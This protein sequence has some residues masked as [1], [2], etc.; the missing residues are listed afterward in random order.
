MQKK[1]ISTLIVIIVLTVA[2]GFLAQKKAVPLPGKFSIATSFYVLG[3]FVENIA[4][5]TVS[6]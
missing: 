6:V 3:N 5:D 2:A 4:G 1:I